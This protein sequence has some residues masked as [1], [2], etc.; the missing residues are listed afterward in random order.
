MIKSTADIDNIAVTFL[1]YYLID[2]HYKLAEP[3]HTKTIAVYA[4]VVGP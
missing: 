1:L 4:L 2:Y 3:L